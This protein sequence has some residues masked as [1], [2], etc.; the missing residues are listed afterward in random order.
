MRLKSKH[1]LHFCT[2]VLANPFGNAVADQILVG[3]RPALEWLARKRTICANPKGSEHFHIEMAQGSMN[4][5]LMSMWL[6]L[7]KPKVMHSIGYRDSV[8]FQHLT[9]AEL[10]EDARLAEIYQD[11]LCAIT[12]EFWTSS[13][14]WSSRYPGRFIALLTPVEA[15]RQQ[16][17]EAIKQDWLLLQS[18]RDASLQSHWAT[19]LLQELQFPRHTFC[20]EVFIMLAESEFTVT[21]E[22]RYML[23]G[24]S[25]SWLGSVLNE[26]CFNFLRSSSS[27]QAA[28]IMGR[29]ARWGSLAASDL[30]SHYSRTKISVTPAAFEHGNKDFDDSFFVQRDPGEFELGAAALDTM[31]DTSWPHPSAQNHKLVGGLM[32]ALRAVHADLT[33]LQDA[34]LSLLVE[35]GTL[36]V[37][38]GQQ[39]KHYVAGVTQWGLITVPVKYKEVGANTWLVPTS[40]GKVGWLTLTSL[41]DWRASRPRLHAPAEVAK[42]NG[43]NFG[44]I[45]MGWLLVQGEGSSIPAL[46]ARQGFRQLTGPFLQKLMAYAKLKFPRGERPTKVRDMAAALIKHF[47]HSANDDFI[48]ACL[49]KREGPNKTEETMA[50]SS[51]LVAEGDAKLLK[52]G[53]ESEDEEVIEKAV[54]KAKQHTSTASA[55]TAKATTSAASSS[56]NWVPKQVKAD[57]DYTAAA[58][59][60]LL[61]N[62]KGCTLHLDEVRFTRWS[63]SYPRVHPPLSITKSYGARTGLTMTQALFHCLKQIW[64]WHAEETGEVC[65]YEFV[66]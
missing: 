10:K 50:Q 23:E 53:V 29:T 27:N 31:D 60:A 47:L 11:M 48:N 12:R 9:E 14:T 7:T 26:D 25:R 55:A 15:Q 2:K 45:C 51:V 56:R 46:S 37:L 39:I 17:A 40:N 24:F 16:A 63:I 13:W 36:L 44:H 32:H 38:P 61:P 1:H 3:C 54:T 52:H 5:L 62:R 22:I 4:E 43:N 20:A 66:L 34:W 8:M 58:A 19:N 59:R 57:K 42:V 28:G 49:R 41:D 6:N 65:P 33:K 30:L 35:P 64:V 21:A 18:L